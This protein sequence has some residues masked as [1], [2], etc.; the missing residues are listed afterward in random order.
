ME[1]DLLTIIGFLQHKPGITKKMAALAGVDLLRIAV[2][3]MPDETVVT[4]DPAENAL[5]HFQA[6]HAM[7]LTPHKIDWSKLISTLLPILLQILGSGGLG[8]VGS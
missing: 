4:G 3:S 2:E 6:V 7:A 5:A 8:A 1:Q